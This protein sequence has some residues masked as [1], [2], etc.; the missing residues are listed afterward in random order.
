MLMAKTFFT[1]LT[2]IKVFA[3]AALVTDSLDREYIT[4]IALNTLVYDFLLLILVKLVIFIFESSS[5]VFALQ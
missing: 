2:V 1:G 4:A 3:D 5:K